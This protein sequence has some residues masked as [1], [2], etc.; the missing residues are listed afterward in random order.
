MKNIITLRNILHTTTPYH[1]SNIIIKNTFCFSKKIKIIV[2]LMMKTV[3][4]FPGKNNFK[5]EQ[6]KMKDN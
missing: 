1:N 2:F 4:M 5:L 3:L 6:T